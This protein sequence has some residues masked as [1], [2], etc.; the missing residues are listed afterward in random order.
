MKADT[1]NEVRTHLQAALDSASL[2]VI[3]DVAPGEDEPG[4]GEDRIYATASIRDTGREVIATR[5]DKYFYEEL[6][7][8]ELVFYITRGNGDKSLRDKVDTVRLFIEQSETASAEFDN[9]LMDVPLETEEKD[10][11]ILLQINI[12]TYTTEDI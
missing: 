10:F 4:T 2:E 1:I 12:R 7:I 3:W 5:D 6:S 9:V 8:A 11:A